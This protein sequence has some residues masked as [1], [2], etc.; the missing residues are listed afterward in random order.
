MEKRRIYV[1][2]ENLD[3]LD[4]ELLKR[5]DIHV[6]L[7]NMNLEEILKE[8]RKEGSEMGQK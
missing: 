6:C 3:K 7:I 2:M 1:S 5:E 8:A 4:K